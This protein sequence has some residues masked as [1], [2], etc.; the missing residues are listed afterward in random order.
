M[1]G[2]G[3]GRGTFAG[4]VLLGAFVLPAASVDFWTRRLYETGRVG[5]PWIVDN[6]SLQGL[7]AR[8]LGEPSPGPAWAL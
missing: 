8:A 2:G 3:H 5:K 1:A 7:I 6:Q 4:T